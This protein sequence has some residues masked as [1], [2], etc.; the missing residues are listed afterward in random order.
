MKTKLTHVAAFLFL[1]VILQACKP[2]PEKSCARAAELSPYVVE[3][4]CVTKL[5][6]LREKNPASFEK[7]GKCIGDAK[8]AASVNACFREIH[9][10]QWA[11][12]KP[13]R[14]TRPREAAPLALPER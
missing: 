14:P 12:E 5:T 11:T 7:V 3:T 6:E 9:A 8:N 13:D 2:T 1:A 10:K 4:D